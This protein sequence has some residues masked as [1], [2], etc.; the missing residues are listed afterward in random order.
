MPIKNDLFR[1]GEWWNVKVS[2]FYGVL[3]IVSI[4]TGQEFKEYVTTIWQTFVVLFPI[5]AWANIINDFADVDSDA[6]A[7]KLNRLSHWSMSKRVIASFGTIP[8]L[9]LAPYLFGYNT[10]SLIFVLTTILAF[11]F[12]SVKPIR[13]KDRG[14]FGAIADAS[15]TQVFPILMVLAL[16]CNASFFSFYH[17]IALGGW[18]VFAGVRLHLVHQFMDYENDLAANLNTIFTVYKKENVIRW[19]KR[20]ILPLE[21]FFL[22]CTL[23]VFHAVYIL[24]GFVWYLLIVILLSKKLKIKFVL[25]AVKT[26]E[27]VWFSEF[28]NSFILIFSLLYL[29]V[30]LN[31]LFVIPLIIF[32]LLF[33]KEIA[34]QGK[35]VLHVLKNWRHIK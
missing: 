30:K 13:L 5:A 22:F 11:I 27:R 1:L 15:G 33:Y 32:G 12:Y 34:L 2:L 6:K 23:Y 29:V 10:L 31:F 3:T 4:Y 7:N 21:L 14:W 8:L 16:E 19:V 24:M 9:F 26:N 28:Y 17:Y 35:E 25:Y 20:I 18:L